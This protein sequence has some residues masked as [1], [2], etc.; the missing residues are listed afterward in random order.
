MNKLILILLPL[1]LCSCATYK[2]EAQGKINS[3]V[4]SAESIEV[5]QENE[6]PGGHHCFEPMLYVLTLGI[7]PT[8]CVDTYKV[9]SESA[10][11]GTVIVTKMQGWVALFMAARPSWQFGMGNEPESEIRNLVQ[12]AN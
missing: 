10:E 7:V 3:V 8:H 12:V 2:I 9:S 6:W 11:I 5:K 1:L 4:A